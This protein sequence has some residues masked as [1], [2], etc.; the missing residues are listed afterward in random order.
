[1]ETNTIC[2]LLFETTL[3]QWNL[4]VLRTTVWDC[5]RL[6]PQTLS[7]DGVWFRIRLSLYVRHRSL[8]NNSVKLTHKTTPPPIAGSRIHETLLRGVVGTSSCLPSTDHPETPSWRSRV[9]VTVVSP[10]VS[11]P[12]S[13]VGGPHEVVKTCGSLEIGMTY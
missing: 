9:G 8:S 3:F 11:H 12:V 2:L 10:E 13:G 6:H 7:V 1:M 4:S 5:R